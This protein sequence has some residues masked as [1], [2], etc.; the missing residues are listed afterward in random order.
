VLREQRLRQAVERLVA[1]PIWEDHGLVFAS[2]AGTTLEPSNVRRAVTS[3][4]TSAGIT[5]TVQPYTARHTSRC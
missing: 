5:W 1:G 4:A 3:V 2:E